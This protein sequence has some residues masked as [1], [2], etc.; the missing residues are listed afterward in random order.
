VR[1]I[2][3]GNTGTW[4]AWKNF[5]TAAMRIETMTTSDSENDV[6]MYPNPAKDEISVQLSEKMAG[7]KADLAI[8][9][10]S[11]KQV[12]K[13]ALQN[14]SDIQKVSVTDIKPGMYSIIISTP[15]NSITRRLNIVK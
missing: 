11:G 2:C 1:S 5:T 15:G 13:S 3:N 10:L 14:T 7:E 9:D 4:S 8:Y 12:F 6:V